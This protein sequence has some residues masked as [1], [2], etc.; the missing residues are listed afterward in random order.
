MKVFYLFC[1]LFFNAV[2]AMNNSNSLQKLSKIKPY[3]G[4]IHWNGGGKGFL[5]SAAACMYYLYKQEYKNPYIVVSGTIGAGLIGS[6]CGEK[7]FLLTEDGKA[8]HAREMFEHYKQSEVVNTIISVKNSGNEKSHAKENR[9]AYP[10][11]PPYSPE[12]KCSNPLCPHEY[13]ERRKNSIINDLRKIYAKKDEMQDYI[14]LTDLNFLIDEF[15]KMYNLVRSNSKAKEQLS[16]NIE[17]SLRRI[18]TA[19]RSEIIVKT[20]KKEKKACKNLQ[21]SS[22]PG[23]NIAPM[24]CKKE[25]DWS[26]V[27]I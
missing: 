6:I 7:I 8:Q 1:L 20:A 21:T 16:N 4:L 11:A 5:L 3:T 26:C 14:I 24:Q 2:F 18:R 23:N 9:Y 12:L 27:I 19:R 13:P 10:S 15:E 17:E 22:F 25:S